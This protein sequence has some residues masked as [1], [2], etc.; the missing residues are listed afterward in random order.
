MD[1]YIDLQINALCMA[2]YARSEEARQS[3]S[4]H[5]LALV[6]VLSVCLPHI[7]FPD[8]S[9]LLASDISFKWCGFEFSS[10]HIYVCLPVLSFREHLHQKMLFPKGCLLRQKQKLCKLILKVQTRIQ[11][12]IQSY[13]LFRKKQFSMALIPCCN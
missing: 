13:H 6:M 9:V 3:H 4:V 10:L 8:L 1:I 11:S 12:W 5:K 2:F 7:F